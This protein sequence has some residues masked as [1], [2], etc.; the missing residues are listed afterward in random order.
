MFNSWTITNNEIRK[1]ILNYVKPDIIIT[2]EM[3]LKIKNASNWRDT[4]GKGLTEE[5]N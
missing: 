1:A 2:C 3:K 4:N 5:S